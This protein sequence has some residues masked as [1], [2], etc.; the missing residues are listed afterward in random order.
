MGA[1]Y[2]LTRGTP[3]LLPGS[4]ATYGPDQTLGMPNARPSAPG[5]FVSMPAGK[6]NH[7]ELSYFQADGDGTGVAK[8]PLSL[9]GSNFTQGDFLSTTYRIR[10]AQLAWNYLTWPAPPEDSKWRLRTLYAFNYTSASPVIDAPYEANVN[11][12][13]AHGTKNIFFPSFG[14]E[15]EYI[16]S[17]RLYFQARTWG[18]GVPHHAAIGDAEVNLVGRIGHLEIFGGYKL[19][20]MKTSPNSDQIFVGTLKGPMAGLRWLFR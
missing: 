16:P 15:L 8:V 3:N 1:F 10:N 13:A 14:V 9:F 5:G 11:F 4:K 6:F 12:V 19:F 17:K 2:W 20:Y 18:F 7:L